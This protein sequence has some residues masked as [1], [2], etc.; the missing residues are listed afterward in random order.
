MI[1]I[2]LVVIF[3]FAFVI[4]HSGADDTPPFEIKDPA[5]NEDFR[6]IY[7]DFSQ[8]THD[9]VDTGFVNYNGRGVFTSCNT[10][11]D[12]TGVILFSGESTLTA[13]S[14]ETVTIPGISNFY[15]PV[16]SQQNTSSLTIHLDLW[17]S[18][19]T[20]RNTGTITNS[21]WWHILGK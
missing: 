13:G 20:I 2:F 15:R 3:L 7:M 21:Y 10:V 5:I 11:V 19:F 1:R 12:L 16:F 9:G 17:V 4:Q 8:H 6:K 14:S 18:S